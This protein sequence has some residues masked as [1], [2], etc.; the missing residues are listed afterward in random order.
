MAGELW[1]EFLFGLRQ[2][3][4]SPGLAASVAV[5][6]GL[7]VGANLAVLALL[8]DT[9]LPRTPLRASDRLVIVEN[10]GNYFFGGNVPEG[11][12]DTRLSAPDFHD[13]EAG[14][15]TLSAMGAFSDG[16]VSILTG[17]ERPRSVRRIFVSSR[18]LELLGIQPVRGRLF[19]AADLAPGAPPVA[20][21]TERLW[22][23][24]F[25][26]DPGITRRTVRLDE[27]P[28]SVVGVIPSRTFALLQEREGLLDDA[29]LERC[30]VTPLVRGQAGESERLFSYLETH[31]DSPAFRA[32]G[33]IRDG[34]SV[35]IARRDLD[36]MAARLRAQNPATNGKRGLGVVAF[37]AWRTGKVLPL[38]L[39]LAAAAALAF[40]VA[41]A[42]AA[43]LVLTESLRRESELGLRQALG[44]GPS[45]LLRV[46]LVRAILWSLPGAILGVVFATATLAVVR[47]GASAGMDQVADI[48]F[49]PRVLAAGLVMTLLAGLATG[50][51]AAWSMRR[52][53]LSESLRE[54]GQTASGGRRQHRVSTVLVALQ[55]ASAT[56]LAI[57][58]ALLLHS[59]W[60]VMSLDRGFDINRGLVVQVRL[61]RSTY[62]KV[63][64]QVKFYQRTLT[65]VRALPGV[66]AAG[67]SASPPL[68][69]TSV[70]LSGDLE[71]DTPA[72]KR[73]LQRL[74]GQFVTTGYFEALGLRLVRGRFFSDADE[75]S[76][77]LAVVVDEAFCRAHL[78]GVDPL[79]STL[80]FGKS[81]LA[82]VGVVGDLRQ[83]TDGGRKR[84]SR[85]W[86]EGL[87]YLLFQ[88]FWSAPTWSFVVVRT[89][90]NPALVADATVRELLAVDHS[91]CLDD[92]RT[93]SQ[94]FAS[95]IAERRR[96]LGLFAGFASIVLLLTA[97]SL[98]AALAQFVT[99][100][101][102]DIAIRFAIGA[103]RRHILMLTSRHLGVALGA[104]LVVG[105]IG[106]LVLARALGSQLFELEPTDPFTLASAI[107]IL[108]LMGLAASA[109]PLWRACRVDSTV[110]LRAL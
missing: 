99:V 25:A 50:G 67:V 38:L 2:F 12:A 39:M 49:A 17:G 92:P 16:H 61:P 103:S 47:W 15:R 93:F 65:R 107:A 58:A 40:L 31:R 4:R 55:I 95:K 30:V 102:R 78:S 62:P 54:G 27:Q 3:R 96:V 84:P 35:E 13:I 52:R 44:A 37:D 69:D 101:S 72:G 11:L 60:N 91:A 10:T 14:Q 28:F 80:R 85:E 105:T 51:V 63:A 59:M 71:V 22:R 21:V 75:Q 33:R 34:S 98:T 43:G 48:Q 36:S 18:M 76:N 53:D 73:A 77:A 108:A 46:V 8:N 68:T 94:L 83:G 1:R 86:N 7:G 9:L 56:T 26:S 97:L 89:T 66:V 104:G 29:T 106:G 5:T 20:L 82:I 70:T 45:Q 64:D 87:A 32:L 88:R 42:N 110:V 79:A 100:H 81:A 41:C 19:G 74:D 23:G 90:G 109:G 57:G 24:Y 6:V